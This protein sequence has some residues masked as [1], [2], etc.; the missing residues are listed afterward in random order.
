MFFDSVA[1]ILIDGTIKSLYWICMY[2]YFRHNKINRFIAQY[3]AITLT[4]V[5]K[6]YTA[7]CSSVDPDSFIS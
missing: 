1:I 6:W 2:M 7:S 5:P 3:M 4:N